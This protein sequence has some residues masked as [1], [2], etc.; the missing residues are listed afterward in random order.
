MK[1]LVLVCNIV[2]LAFT[3][4][5]IA[6]EGLSTEAIY[7]VVTLLMIV[8]PTFTLLAI[9]RPRTSSA[10]ATTVVR[11]IAMCNLVLLAFVC[12]AL[13]DQYPHPNE[14]GC[15][16]YVAVVILTL[17]LSAVVLLC[18]RPTELRQS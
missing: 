11:L 13:V 14:P 1:A 7:I 15:V 2:S 9:A 17:I 5:V 6:G 12:W 10:T 16:P 4:L 18:H 3:L 8:I